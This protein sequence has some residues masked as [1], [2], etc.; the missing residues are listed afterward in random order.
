MK[1]TSGVKKN[2]PT[3]I[4]KPRQNALSRKRSRSLHSNALDH[5]HPSFL[6]KLLEESCV[7]KKKNVR[8]NVR[9]SISLVSFQ[10]DLVRNCQPCVAGFAVGGQGRNEN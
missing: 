2:S 10:I 7:G 8:S 3:A 6:R 1:R 5:R 9:L 4:L